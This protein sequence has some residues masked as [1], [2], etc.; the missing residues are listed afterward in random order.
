MLF[1]LKTLV[2]GAALFALP[3]RADWVEMSSGDLQKTGTDEDGIWYVKEAVDRY[4]SV[5]PDEKRQG[6]F[7][8]GGATTKEDFDNIAEFQESESRLDGNAVQFL[9]VFS[10]EEDFG[11]NGMGLDANNRNHLWWRALNRVSKGT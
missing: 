3:L 8:A 1:S 9:D 5:V 6:L 10:F 11:A 7:W 2:V 4:N